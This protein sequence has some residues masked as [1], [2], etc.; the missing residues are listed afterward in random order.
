MASSMR[1]LSDCQGFATK[2]FCL[3]ILFKTFKPYFTDILGVRLIV[4]AQLA[5]G[6]V[7]DSLETRFLRCCGKNRGSIKTMINSAKHDKNSWLVEF[8][9]VHLLKTSKA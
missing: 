1:V 8:Y 6:P 4:R 2:N 7:V 5:L 9:F 3:N